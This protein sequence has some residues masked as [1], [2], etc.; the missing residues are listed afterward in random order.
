MAHLV[1]GRLLDFIQ[2][3]DDYAIAKLYPPKVI[4]DKPLG[5]SVVRTKYRVTVVGVK[6]PGKEFTYATEETV[7]TNHDLVIVSGH[8]GDI[9]RFASLDR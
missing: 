5:R 6:S 7:I 8:V 1:S 2:F 3:D 4:R 9:E